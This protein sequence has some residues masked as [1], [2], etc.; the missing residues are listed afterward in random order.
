MNPKGV[1]F[2]EPIELKTDGSIT[3]TGEPIVTFI[4][5]EEMPK[6]VRDHPVLKKQWLN[7]NKFFM[8]RNNE[9]TL[10]EALNDYRQRYNWMRI[11]NLD[12]P[13]FS[14]NYL[15]RQ[16]EYYCKP[17]VINGFSIIDTLDI[18]NTYKIGVV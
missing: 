6:T 16:Q 17:A 7:T 8:P 5:G 15:P 18:K 4:Y 11:P 3:K 1:I 9:K 2:S 13:L 14:F 10:A 12:F